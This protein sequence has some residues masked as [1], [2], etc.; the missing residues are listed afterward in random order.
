MLN[1]FDPE[2]DREMCLAGADRSGAHDFFPALDALAFGGL[3]KLRPLYLVPNVPVELGLG[4]EVG[5]A[6][7]A[8]EPGDRAVVADQDLGS[9]QLQ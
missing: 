4:L 5:E 7:P 8:Q 2:H 9:E 6:S 1:G 3:R